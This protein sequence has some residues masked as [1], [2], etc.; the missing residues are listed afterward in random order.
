MLCTIKSQLLQKVPDIPSKLRAMAQPDAPVFSQLTRF[1]LDVATGRHVLSLL[2]PPALWL[3]D[4]VLTGLIIWKVPCTLKHLLLLLSCMEL[5]LHVL[6]VWPVE[7][8]E[9]DWVAYME[10]VTQFVEGERNYVKMEGGTGPLVYPAA[11]VY[12]YTGLYY[13]TDKGKDIFLA[14]QIFGVLY[15]ATLTLVMLCYSKA[16]VGSTNWQI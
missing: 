16:K 6:T 5:L 13:I 3:L 14:Q 15:M 10:Q 1:A 9:I 2:I 12:I 8:T 11:H 4:A 7:D